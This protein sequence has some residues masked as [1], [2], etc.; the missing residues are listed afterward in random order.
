MPN[1][2]QP[3][4]SARHDAHSNRSKQS[5]EKFM[6]RYFLFVHYATKEHT[7]YNWRRLLGFQLTTSFEDRFRADLKYLSEILRPFRDSTEEWWEGRAFVFVDL[8]WTRL[9]AQQEGQL[10]DA[11][12]LGGNLAQI[13]NALVQ[14]R[15]EANEVQIIDAFDLLQLLSILDRSLD[16]D[17]RHKF[18]RF[19]VGGLGGMRYDAPKVAEA[20]IRIAN[21]GRQVPIFRLDD[22]VI[23]FGNRRREAGSQPR[24]TG[25]RRKDDVQSVQKSIAKLCER[26]HRVSRNPRIHYFAF[27]GTYC[28]PPYDEQP[29]RQEAEREVDR[30]NEEEVINGFATR[31]VQL[32]ELPRIIPSG[33]NEK[34]TVKSSKALKFLRGLINYGANPFRQV[35]SGAGLCLSDGA[36]LD[37]PPYSNMRLNVM[38]I[39]D[40]L[41]FSLHHELGHF[42]IHIGEVGHARVGE[43]RFAQLRHRDA[44]TYK[45][46]VWH[47][48]IY[49]LRLVMGCVADGWLRASPELKRA[50]TG[51]LTHDQIRDLRKKYVPHVYA[52]EFLEVL[53][54]KY[55]SG[56]D[57]ERG[58]QF[59]QRLWTSALARL[60]EVV[61]GWSDDEFRSTFLGLF[62]TGE[63]P[64]RWPKDLCTYLPEQFKHGLSGAVK[65]LPEQ[66]PSDP[67]IC[68]DF[69]KPSLGDALRILVDDFVEYLDVVQFWK[70]FVWSV[71]FLLNRDRQSDEIKRPGESLDWMYP[72]DETAP[73]DSGVPRGPKRKGVKVGVAKRA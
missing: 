58:K 42:D 60:K 26:Y 23:Y 67:P 34:A 16:E 43:A 6:R 55:A 19:L 46:V 38:W 29:G 62:A 36:I 70:F 18:K 64:D 11:F 69:E 66:I 59:R 50:L 8:G 12:T 3:R 73:E 13:H 4:T 56:S 54:G 7:D 48:N 61:K 47:M 45:D 2:N 24:S 41:K 52:T 20:A 5:K 27:S 14:L 53:P 44:P 9:L 1:A 28:Q 72:P 49:M 15:Q 40:H 57:A 63:V 65:E 33:L 68:K 10:I 22:D 35:I 39:D 71:R 30:E 37:L 31:V 51:R 25:D 17:T 32:A 21:I